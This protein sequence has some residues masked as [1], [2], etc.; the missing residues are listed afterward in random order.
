MIS[1]KLRALKFALLLVVVVGALPVAA[2][3]SNAVK[4]VTVYYP[5]AGNDWEKRKP[6]QVGMDASLLAAAVEYVKRQQE[7][8]SINE[9]IV[10]RQR[11]E[12][13]FGAVRPPLPDILGPTKERGASSGVIIRHGYIVAEFGAT[14][15]ADM[16][17]SVTKSF[18]SA[19]AGLAVDR[20]LIRSIDEP[21]K[22]YVRDGN[23]DSPHNS[24]ITWRH[25]LEQT[26]E[27]EG[28]LWGK[29]AMLDEPAG[30]TL[31]E[32]GTFWNYNDTRVNLLALAL[33]R[34][35]QEPLPQVL[36]KEVMNPIGASGTWEWH[37][38]RSSEVVIG[39][40]PMNSVSGG[41]HWGGGLF[42]SARDLARF[43]YL[44]LRR[45]KWKDR[46][47]ISERW[48]EMSTTASAVKE[49]YG[50]LWWL[51][52]WPGDA[53]ATFAARG[54]GGNVVWVDPNNDLVVVLRWATNHDE[55]FKR[56]RAAVVPV[57][58]GS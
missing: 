28:A 26:S 15:R 54:A 22:N 56:V 16:T 42:I 37:G 33:L 8:K 19:L 9:V 2:Q 6:E 51:K 11:Q 45:G 24:K 17:F 53:K 39:G 7:T 29:P 13:N 46:Q 14:D 50:L 23:F 49:D 52:K 58:H 10:A 44:Y 43:G 48:V 30:H 18:L 3:R 25:L 21:V 4:R 5:G 12:A 57:R 40:W 35:M 31:K 55:I 20:G 41:G 36:K 1:A 32:P 47:V 27:W 38:Y 34:L